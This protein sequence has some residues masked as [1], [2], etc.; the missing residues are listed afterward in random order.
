MNKHDRFAAVIAA[1]DARTLSS[2]PLYKR[3]EAFDDDVNP[4]HEIERFNRD[5]ALMKGYDLVVWFYLDKIPDPAFRPGIAAAYVVQFS[6]LIVAITSDGEHFCS[7]QD[8][9]ED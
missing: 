2:S 1:G 5:T 8:P 3:I 7:I 4:I 6:W 9:R